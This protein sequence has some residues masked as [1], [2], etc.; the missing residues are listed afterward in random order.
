M[1]VFWVSIRISRLFDR[2]FTFIA[3]IAMSTTYLYSNNSSI[4]GCDLYTQRAAAAWS[5]RSR[6]C[7]VRLLDSGEIHN[8]LY[9]VV[10]T[11]ILAFSREW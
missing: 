9:N 4:Q 7:S 1:P 8:T 3:Y 2:F 10:F 6:M 5:D 11:I